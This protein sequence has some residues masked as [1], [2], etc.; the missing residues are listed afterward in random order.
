MSTS[1]NAIVQAISEANNQYRDQSTPVRQKLEALWEIGDCLTKMGVTRPHSIGWAIQRETGGLIKRPTVFRSHKIRTIWPSKEELTRDLGKLQ[2]LSRL[3]ELLPLIDPDQAIRGR[4]SAQQIADLYKH[5]CSDGAHQ[6]KGYL[7]TLK[8]QLSHGKL[9]KP[10]DRNKH[11]ANLR[12]VVLN[13]HTL[14]SFL[15]KL[16]EQVHPEERNRARE[17]IPP[18]ELQAFS[19]M[20]IALTTKD[21]YRLYRQL[22]PATSNSSKSE[23]KFLYDRFRQ[24]L[25]KTADVERARLRRLI[26][27]E[28]FAQMSDLVSSLTSE[29]GVEDFKARQKI[30]IP[31]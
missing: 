14:Q 7:S 9:G 31:F 16:L 23:F 18:E 8:K 3:T 29:A 6:F 25:S 24:I 20:C 4:L 5:A 1:V 30:A 21:N 27:P 22:L 11:L 10:L 2:G 19:N 15:L 12:E 17:I 28:A 26:S 13:F